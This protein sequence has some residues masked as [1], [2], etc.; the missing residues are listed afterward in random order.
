MKINLKKRF[1][2]EPLLLYHLCD[3]K[4]I[5]QKKEQDNEM[6]TLKNFV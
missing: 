1:R 2:N 4:T 3:T 5:V 6:E